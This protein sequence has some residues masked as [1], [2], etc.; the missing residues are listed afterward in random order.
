MIFSVAASRKREERAPAQEEVVADEPV[1]RRAA[2]EEV[3]PAVLEELDGERV[4]DLGGVVGER[5]GQRARHVVAAR[6]RVRH[7]LRL[8]LQP[9]REL[10]AGLD[11]P[12]RQLRFG[13]ERDVEERAVGDG[14]CRVQ[15]LDRA[16]LRLDEPRDVAR[17][18]AADG[19]ARGDVRERAQ[20]RLRRRAVR[21][22]ETG[23]GV[24]RELARGER[25]HARAV[26][27]D[28]R[29]ARPRRGRRDRAH[30]T[31]GTVE[32]PNND[33]AVARI[34]VGRREAR[35]EHHGEGID[36]RDRAENE[37]GIDERE[38]DARLDRFAFARQNDG[39]DGILPKNF[40]E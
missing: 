22:A 31:V 23:V 12:G 17:V 39:H 40:F 14:P 20:K 35:G 37:C 5:R 13:G 26:L 29:P 6:A 25:G 7:V 33:G 3:A 38:E 9:R 28:L 10:L 18:V 32:K 36:H 1:V 2:F 34:V 21:L 15:P 16:V 24:G 8:E 30:E 19:V 11:A 27:R 4:A